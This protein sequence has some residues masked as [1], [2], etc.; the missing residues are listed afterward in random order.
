MISASSGS[1]GVGS[2]GFRSRKL[3]GAVDLLGLDSLSFGIVALDAVVLGFLFQRRADGE[4]GTDFLTIGARVSEVAL[5]LGGFPTRLC[6]TYPGVCRLMR[7]RTAAIWLGES[8][9]NMA[10]ISS[11]LFPSAICCLTASSFPF[12]P[13]PAHH[14]FP[15]PSDMSWLLPVHLLS[16]YIPKRLLL[17]CRL[18]QIFFYAFS[19]P[20]VDQKWNEHE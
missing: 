8:R 20:A 6:A 17:I 14:S 7:W 18:F 15:Y 5:G 1:C 9:L 16:F 10:L 3:K 12:G 19:W 13:N 4:D 2:A 11:L